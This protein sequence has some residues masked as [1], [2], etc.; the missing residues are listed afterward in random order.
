MNQKL[1]DRGN[2]ED[3]KQ[4]PNSEGVWTIEVYPKLLAEIRTAMELS[5]IITAAIPGLRRDMTAFTDSTL[6]KIN[7][8]VDFPNVMI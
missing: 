5:K 6:P 3:Y 1:H 4:I 8:T 7:K 2:G